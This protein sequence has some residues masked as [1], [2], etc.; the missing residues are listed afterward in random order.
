MP[1]HPP[2]RCGPFMWGTPMRRAGA[3]ETWAVSG[4]KR[5]GSGIFKTYP[6]RRGEKW[7]ATPPPFFLFSYAILKGTAVAQSHLENRIGGGGWCGRQCGR[8]TTTPGSHPGTIQIL[9]NEPRGN[10]LVVCQFGAECPDFQELHFICCSCILPVGAE[11][12]VGPLQGRRWLLHNDLAGAELFMAPRYLPINRS[13]PSPPPPSPPHTLF[14][15]TQNDCLPR[16]GPAM[17]PFP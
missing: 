4:K 2:S 9:E 3:E 6:S 8:V 10:I 5:R 15:T 1:D 12:T 13:P 14:R 16:A 7:S 11:G 17:L